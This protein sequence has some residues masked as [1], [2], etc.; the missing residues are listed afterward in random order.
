MTVTRHSLVKCRTRDCPFTP[1]QHDEWMDLCSRAPEHGHR[2]DQLTHQH[3]PKKGM[4]GNNPLAKIVAVL[5]WPFHDRV[6]NG[7]WSNDVKDMPGRGRVYFAQDLHGNTLIEKEVMPD[8]RPQHNNI[9][10]REVGRDGQVLS[11]AAEGEKVAKVP[12]GRQEPLG[13]AEVPEPL[14]ARSEG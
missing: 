12:S 1:D 5:C 9:D 6:D 7:D 11:A 3:H 2:H 4:G 8:A 14:E 10:Q 13:S